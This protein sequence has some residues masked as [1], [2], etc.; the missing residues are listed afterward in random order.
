MSDRRHIL[1]LMLGLLVLTGSSPAAITATQATSNRHP[2]CVRFLRPTF[3]GTEPLRAVPMIYTN[4]VPIRMIPD[5]SPLYSDCAP[6]KYGYMVQ[7]YGVPIA[8]ADTLRVN[9]ESRTNRAVNES[10]VN[11]RLSPSQRRFVERFLGRYNASD[12]AFWS[13][14][15]GQVVVT[16]KSDG[17]LMMTS[18][19]DITGS[20][21]QALIGPARR[22]R[23]FP[24][25]GAEA[26]VDVQFK[27]H[28]GNCSRI[29]GRYVTLHYNRAL[30]GADIYQIEVILHRD[31]W[32]GQERNE[33]QTWNLSKLQPTISTPR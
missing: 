33:T 21:C 25:L 17:R 27:L 1:K 6:G 19:M 23:A 15:A 32:R 2:S 31:Y 9:L 13:A 16:L 30:T 4:G 22:L 10:I 3:A 7:P 24:T 12:D 20:D 14:V 5:N 29:S 8:W 11:G 28:K 26:S 18:S